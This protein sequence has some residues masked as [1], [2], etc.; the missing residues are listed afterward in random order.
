MIK[1]MIIPYKVTINFIKHWSCYNRKMQLWWDNK[2]HLFMLRGASKTI[3]YQKRLYILSLFS[4]FIRGTRVAMG[5]LISIHQNYDVDNSNRTCFCIKTQKLLNALLCVLHVFLY[6][7][8]CV[9]IRIGMSWRVFSQVGQ[10]KKSDT[11]GVSFHF[12]ETG[13]DCTHR[14]N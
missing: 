6:V 1:N 10:S 2:V 8:V 3:L 14:C 12:R 9:C 11:S 13:F 4:R 5:L 7:Y